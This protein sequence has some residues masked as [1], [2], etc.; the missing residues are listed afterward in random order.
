[1][2]KYAYKAVDSNGK[3][4]KGKVTADTEKEVERIVTESGQTLV[5]VHEVVKKDIQIFSPR[6]VTTIKV[7][8]LTTFTYQL[9]TYLDSGVPLMSALYDLSNSPEDP[10][11]GVIVYDIY[12]MIE[13][14]FSFEESLKKYPK[15]F[16]QLYVG[17]VRSG[18]TTGNLA[19]V[20]K[21]LSGY[22]EWQESL[23]AQV[24]Q[25][26]MYPL[27][28]FIA[29]GGA[30]ILLVTFVFPKFIGIFRGM[31]IE[32][33]L[34]TE[35]LI[36]LSEFIKLRWK[37]I[38]IG[39]GLLVAGLKTFIK[40]KQGH[41]LYDKLQLHLPI[42]GILMKKV[43]ISRFAHTFSMS[44]RSGIDVMR[45]LDLCVDVVG[46][47]VVEKDIAA[48]RDKVN[49]GENLSDAFRETSEFPALITRMVAVG[50]TSG[51]LEETVGKVS[52]YY[53]TEVPK[54]INK[55]FTV[56]EPLMLV[57]MGLGVGFIAFS[58]FVPLFSMVGAVK[59]H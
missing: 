2:P 5:S 31:G 39:T 12:S 18:E 6:K 19:G 7:T 34:S 8:S 28:L 11:V 55:V 4:I 37:L 51:T 13:K 21:Y 49:I 17:S 24:K 23:K 47:K 35:F 15:I 10:N 26:M 32:I 54:T 29:I 1:M 9:A 27:I 59:S 46:N 38:L 44:L 16:D 45:A 53:D 52:E 57:V 25:A 41:L 40:T 43:C 42:F 48:I 20:L 3:Y 50:E 36:W 33:P 56:L 30:I 58:I 22:L 14:G